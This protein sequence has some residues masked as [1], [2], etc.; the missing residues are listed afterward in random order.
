MD[1]MESYTPYG[2]A[3]IVARED[4]FH[5][6]VIRQMPRTSSGGDRKA[7]AVV[8]M[9]KHGSREALLSDNSSKPNSISSFYVGINFFPSRSDSN[10]C[11]SRSPSFSTINQSAAHCYLLLRSSLHQITSTLH[12]TL[13]TCQRWFGA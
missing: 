3:W 11:G 10:Y 9:W 7:V 6:H 2:K 1:Y 5:L 8:V 4:D 13:Q 12:S